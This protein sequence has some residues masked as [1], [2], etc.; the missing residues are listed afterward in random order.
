[1]PARSKDSA[2]VIP[3][4]L[5][6]E[7]FEDVRYL[8]QIAEN[9][10][11]V[12]P[13]IEDLDDDNDASFYVSGEFFGL[14]RMAV[15]MLAAAA[16]AMANQELLEQELDEQHGSD[17]LEE[18]WAALYNR[19]GVKPNKG[20]RPWQ[21][22]PKL[23]FLR[24]R[25]VHHVPTEIILARKPQGS[26]KLELLGPDGQEVTRLANDI[27]AIVC[28]YFDRQDPEEAGRM[29]ADW[30]D[31]VSM[32]R[33]LPWMNLE[34]AG[35]S[36]GSSRSIPTTDGQAEKPTKNPRDNGKQRPTMANDAKQNPWSEALFQQN[37]RSQILA[38]SNS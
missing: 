21:S 18:K 1:M 33:T 7:L 29:R 22:L 38:P 16:E 4:V 8:L 3:E 19:I 9:R 32:M 27:H 37:H 14:L 23:S 13:R 6:G 30:R 24:N 26:V 5:A 35:A 28:T 17:R 25:L 15:I 11:T 12:L 31:E 20:R 2:L 10:R 34:D 36:Q